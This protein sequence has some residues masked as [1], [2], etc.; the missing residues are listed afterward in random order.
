MIDQRRV[1]DG[2][3]HGLERGFL[4]NRGMQRA[5]ARILT[6]GDQPVSRPEHPAV[7]LASGE[8]GVRRYYHVTAPDLGYV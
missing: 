6:V 5:P 1:V 7:C 2:S 8:Y 3:F 4:K